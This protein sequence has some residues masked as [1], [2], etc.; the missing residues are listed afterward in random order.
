MT[1]S[2]AAVLSAVAY[3]GLQRVVAVF[4]TMVNSAMLL[5]LLLIS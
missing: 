3:R 2:N 4:N 5:P 1:D